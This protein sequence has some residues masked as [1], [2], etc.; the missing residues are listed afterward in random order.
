MRDIDLF[1]IGDSHASFWNGTGDEGMPDSIPGIRTLGIGGA[2]AYSLVKETS[3]SQA[4]PKAFA[5]IREALA[6]GFSGWILLYFGANDCNAWTWRQVPRLSLQQSVCET[7][8]RYTAFIQ[9]VRALHP[10]VAVF[11]PPAATLISDMG[12]QAERNLAVLLFTSMLEGRLK[13]SGVPVLSMAR[14]MIDFDG[15][16]MATM[17]RKDAMHVMQVLLPY[18]LQIVNSRLGLRVGGKDPLFMQESRIEHFQSI[19]Y[20]D[21]FDRTWLRYTLPGGSHYLK[22]VAIWPDTFAELGKLDFG[23]TI[24]S[25]EYQGCGATFDP[26]RAPTEKQFI[27]LGYH[28]R[29]VLIASSERKSEPGDVEFYQY[30][31][32]IARHRSYFRDVLFALH[33]RIMADERLV[34]PLIPE[35]EV[36]SA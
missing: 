6:A 7:V 22:S 1:V 3:R 5:G 18:A 17:Y 9:E 29:E 12:S 34:S 27:P 16:S 28:A 33:D 13:P 32:H 11:G 26:S 8:D 20:C 21:M 31:S 14:I 2:T 23:F 36:I 19:D 15:N 4:R 24:N 35:R 25:L 30:G 10:K